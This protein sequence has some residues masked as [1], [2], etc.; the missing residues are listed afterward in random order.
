MRGVQLLVLFLALAGG[1][2]A[3]ERPQPTGGFDLTA[4]ALW[5]FQ[6]ESGSSTED[7][8]GAGLG[9]GYRLPNGLAFELR[10]SYRSWESET[11]VP[12]HL[13]VRYELAV[14]DL[15]TVAPFAGAGPS[16]VSG[17]DWASV[18]ASFDVGARVDVALA[19]DSRVRLSLEAGYGRAMTFHPSEFGVL[20]LGAGL[21]L[22]L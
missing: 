10:G 22:T 4:Q 8:P 5:S 15:V 14:H 2:A 18:F 9:L 1:A 21:R 17:N 11:Y 12:L 20:N 3:Q 7:T 16:V 13:G 6:Y 19:R